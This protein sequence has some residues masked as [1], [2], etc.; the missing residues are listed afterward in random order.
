M[1]ISTGW[2]SM[3]EVSIEKLKSCINVPLTTWQILRPA[4]AF[5]I[6][7]ISNCNNYKP[8]L[9]FQVLCIMISKRVII[10]ITTNYV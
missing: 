6:I 8:N 1:P 10:E 4:N 7:V 9:T 2:R 3:G 5:V